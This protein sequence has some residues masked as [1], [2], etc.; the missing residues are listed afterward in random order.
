[1]PHSL[2]QLLPSLQSLGIWTYWII[3]LFALLEAT[4]GIGIVAPGA[5]VVFAGGM[6]VQRGVLDV[7]D[8]GWFVIVGTVL[9]GEISYRLGRLAAH[10]LKGSR[11]FTS[12]RYTVRAKALLARYG[13]L[14][15]LIGRLSGPLSAFVPFSAAIAGME[16]R[17]FVLWN[18]VSAFP[19]ALIHLSLGYFVGNAIG[20]MG[21]AAPRILAV[22]VAVFLV[23]ALL[24]YLLKRLRRALPLMAVILRATATGLAEKPFFRRLNER[25]PKLATFVAGR[26]DTSRFLGLTATVLAVLFVYVFA[27]YLDSVFDFLTSPDVA[28]ADSRVANMFYALRDTRLIAL[29]GWITALG[30]WKIVLSMMVGATIALTILRRYDLAG[31]LWIA[32][33]G[34]QLCVALLKSFFDR[35]RSPL[36]Y[37]TE[38]S[39]SF[40]SGHAAASVAIWGMLFYLAWRIRLLSAEVATLAAVALAFLIGFSRVYLVEHYLSDVLNGYLVGGLW[41]IVGVAFCEW[42]CE[43]VGRRAASQ[44]RPLALGVIAV[45]AAVALVLASTLSSPLTGSRN[46]PRSLSMLRWPSSPPTRRREA[47]TR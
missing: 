17:R 33:A 30:S 26:F 8:L 4:I 39:G 42:R 43:V 12:S 28:S 27:I 11:R 29:F 14:A 38:T 34:N 22:G 24:W 7:F 16:R 15:M 9:G 46:L 40:P 19:Y 36:G 6:L 5:L 1:M 25:H 13:A 31:A 3:G 2:D 32:A 41:L 35:P 20:T 44:N 23:L 37:F 47:P 10:G 21:A 18:V 45:A